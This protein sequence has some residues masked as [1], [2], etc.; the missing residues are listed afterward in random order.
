[1]FKTASKLLFGLAAAGFMMAVGYAAV[2]SHRQGSIESILGPITL[3][4][5][6][7]VGDHAGYAVLVGLSFVSLFLGGP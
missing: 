4:Y 6:G 1:M 7:P 5:K 3:G 2:T